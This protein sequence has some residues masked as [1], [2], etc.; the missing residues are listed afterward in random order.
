MKIAILAVGSQGDVRPYSALGAG[1]AQA[2]HAVRFA[3]HEAFRGHIQ[4]LGLEFAPIKLNPMEIVQGETGQAWL[5]SMDKPIRFMRSISA[6]AREVLDS[7]NDDA[8]AA[9]QGCDAVIFSLPL[10]ISGLTMAEVLGIPGIPGAL[11]P[12]HATW[13][14]PSI[15]TP[16][17]P[18]QGRA[19]NRLSALI[20]QQV[21]WHVFRSH[22]NRWR[23][24]RL[25]LPPLPF[26]LPLA[27]MRRQGVPVLYGY[28]PTVIPVP[29]DWHSSYTVCG[30][31]FPPP[32]AGWTPP[33]ALTDFL[34]SGPAPLYIG[35]G[36]MASADPQRMTE[37]VL[38][39]LRIT[40]HR[41]ILASGWG[42]LSAG[43]LSENVLR[44]ESVPHEWLFPRVAAAVHHGGAGTTAAALRAG[45]PSVVVSFFADQFFWGNRL[46]ELGAGSRPLSQKNLTAAGLAEAI[47]SVTGSSA[48]QARCRDLARSISLEKGVATAVAAVERYLNERTRRV[49]Q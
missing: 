41:A 10:S 5:A 45:V 29:E 27:G 33:A 35:F 20:V 30:Y 39:A 26:R 28:S 18:L 34:G 6:L 49:I 46:Y 23:K 36:S 3:T 11:Y 40:G 31:W 1:L 47:L 2:G 17:L 9:C 4:S 14:F 32:Q 7:V 13:V 21:F 8:W 48:V 44:V 22:Q 25:H 16:Q 37:I 38:E 24:S 12:L 43:S 19:M 15:M 42:G